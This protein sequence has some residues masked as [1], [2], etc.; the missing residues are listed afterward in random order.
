MKE[1]ALYLNGSLT[2][3]SKAGTGTAIKASI[4]LTEPTS[5]E[6]I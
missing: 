4:P 6:S 5:K 1:R 3:I 2:I